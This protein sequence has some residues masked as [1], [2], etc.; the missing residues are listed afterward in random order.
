MAARLFLRRKFFT[1]A[2][3][4]DD[5]MQQHIVKVTTMAEQLAAIGASVSDEDTVM[6]LLCSLPAD[7]DNLIVSLESRVD[8][9]T[10]D[11]V[12]SR[13][14][15]EEARRAEAQQAAGEETVLVARGNDVRIKDGR[16]N[17]NRLIKCYRCQKRGHIARNCPERQ[18]DAERD[19]GRVEQA[20]QASIEAV[21]ENEFVFTATGQG[22]PGKDVWLID[23]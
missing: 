18:Q 1:L 14:L 10:L 16:G 7:F 23:S 3:A 8:G 5:T 13:L 9:L 12:S 19:E 2:K 20:N 6:T 4:A 15:H 17:N 21:G 11:F 22:R